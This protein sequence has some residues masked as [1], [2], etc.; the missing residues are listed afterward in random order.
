MTDSIE[1]I[2]PPPIDVV[3][4]SEGGGAS[5]WGTV[6][7]D[8]QDQLDLV[9]ELD[10]KMDITDQAV[11][12]DL[13]YNEL[14][15]GVKT[16]MV[17]SINTDPTLFN[18]SP[19]V[20]LTVDN[21]DPLNPVLTPVS[22]PGMEAVA[23]PYIS[24][25]NA[26][27]VGVDSTGAVV[28]QTTDFTD[29]QRRSLIIL[30]AIIH[31]NRVIANVVNNLPDVS[32]SAAS[33]VNDLMAGLRNFNISGNIF[34]AHGADLFINK[35]AGYLFKKGSN[36][37]S[38]KHSPHTNFL[39]ALEAPATLRYRLRNGTEYPN[40][41]IVDPNYYDLNGVRT[42]V[43]PN[44]YTIQ[45][46]TLFPSN[47]IRIQYGQAQYQSKVEAIQ[48]ISTELFV[49]EQNIAE[50][51]L[52]RALLVVKRG[53][54]ALNVMANAQFF[55]ADKFGSTRFSASGTAVTTL[56][57]AYNNSTIPQIVTTPEAK[58]LQIQ[59]GSAADTD[60]VQEYL[61]G[62]GAV[63]ASISGDGSAIFGNK[64]AGNFSSFEPDG[65][66]KMTGEAVVFDDISLSGM[67]F[68]AGGS[69][70]P[71]IIDFVNANLKTY[72][73]DG[74]ATTERLYITTEM[75]HAYREGS[76]L[77]LHIHW[78]PTTVGAGN[79]KWQVYYSWV[80]KDG[81]YT[82]PALLSVVAAAR[83]Q[84]WQN[85]YS[86][87]G[88]ISGV[89]RTINSQLVLQLFRDPSDVA[90]TYAGDAALIAFGIHYEKDTVGSRTRLGK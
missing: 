57:Q 12:D 36:F 14:S 38:N 34:S 44:R 15:N 35:N 43:S 32:L 8:I 11:T 71:D 52:L 1:V 26:T 72:G 75:Q 56:Q 87:F 66:Y 13:L 62:S 55:E 46:F 7:G 82:A 41:S 19:G 88:V 23:L 79:V 40:T 84:A 86:T 29:I 53:T 81:I 73:F 4:S 16:G 85:T 77:E 80:S 42:P 3:V 17:L 64:T 51:G 5:V 70:A 39:A 58:A 24:L 9:A 25:V 2:L 45:R 31:S 28:Q 90:D 65:T 50:N 33:Q 68:A 21:S 10:L 20:G 22:F 74:G 48:A 69:A 60:T 37:R 47:L 63:R 30:G 18:I 54:T 61:D 6:S 89:G 67:S 83:G 76:D 27:Y 49:E 78:A 59:R